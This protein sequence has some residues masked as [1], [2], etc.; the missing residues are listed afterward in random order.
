MVLGLAVAF[1]AAQIVVGVATGSLAVL[2]DAGYMATNA[3]GVAM[4]LAAITAAIRTGRSMGLGARTVGLYRL[5]IRAALVNS[6]LLVAVGLYVLVEAA[7]RIGRD[8]AA[9]L[10][11]WPVIAIGV[12]G[13][14]V[15]ALSM[16]LL[17]EGAADNLNVRGAY[18]DVVS[19]AVGSTAV[20]VSGVLTALLGWPWIDAVIGAAIGVFILPR[21]WHLGREAIR[22]LGQAAP[23]RLDPATVSAQLASLDGVVDVH[24]LHIWTLTSEMDVVTAHLAIAPEADHGAVLDAGRRLLAHAFGL[25]HATLRIEGS[26]ADEA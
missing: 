19:D 22:V 23:R 5:E 24:D 9:A 17:R 15:N 2:A 10:T 6:V 1:L 7:D 18:L 21:A 12:A 26:R 14:G 3:L 25:D 4:S 8:D 20:I 13:L 11:A 16:M